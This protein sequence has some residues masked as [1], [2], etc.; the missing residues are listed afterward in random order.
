MLFNSYEFLFLYFPVTFAVFF[1]LARYRRSLAAL[2]LFGAS[3]FFYGWWNPAY[4]SLLIGSILFNFGMGTAISREHERGA[5]RRAKGLLIAAISG[6][7]A[8]LAYYKYANFFLDNVN[9]LAGAQWHLEAIILPLGISF[10]TFTQ[11]AFL[12]DSY[13]GEVKERNFIHYGLFVTYFPHLIAGPVLHHKEMMP[14]FAEAKTYRLHWENISVGLTIFI[15]GLFKKLVLADGVAPFATPVFNAAANGVTLTLIDA[16]V[17]ALAFTLQLYFDFSAYSDMAIGLS[18]MFGVK[19]PLNFNSPYK[20]V[21]I[22]DFWR[23]WHMTLS[24]FLRDYLYFAL[25]GNR[26]GAIRRYVNLMVTM[27]LGGLWH[28]AGWTFIIWG[29]LHGL[30]LSINHAW[31]KF[32]STFLNL[33]PVSR[34]EKRAAWLLTF[35]AV[36]VGWVF[37]R[38]QDT[39]SAVSILHAMTG[40]NGLLVPNNWPAAWYLYAVINKL[41]LPVQ[42]GVPVSQFDP[43]GISLYWIIVLLGIAWF[44]PNTQQL[45]ARFDPA[46][47]SVSTPNT[48]PIWQPGAA[49]AVVMGFVAVVAILHLTRVSEFLYFQF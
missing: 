49:W 47:E 45:M 36:V 19:L 34:V 24:R 38:A 13:R 7:L 11:I 29:G 35:L 33:L 39:Q 17:G 9:L 31:T 25:G 12:V 22:V 1:A 23:R 30:Y 18:R 14:Q 6:D 4:V 2:W 8:L 16:W 37:F 40:G 27:L 28:G 46:L 5:F 32:R 41:G 42:L 48:P 20:A 15:I 43:A 21:N 26:K 10:F 44:M 3:L